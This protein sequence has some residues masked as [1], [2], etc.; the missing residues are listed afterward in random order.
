MNELPT[1]FVVR[2]L[3]A[4]DLPAAQALLDACET[5]DTGEPTM[6]E[7]YLAVESRSPR[8][9]FEHGAW[10]IDANDGALAGVGWMRVPGDRGISMADHYV[11]PDL[12]H[13]AL[14]DVFLDLIEAR[15]AEY[16]RDSGHDGL[17]ELP[18]RL[19]TYSEPVLERRRELLLARGFAVV[20]GTFQMRLDL[21]GPIAPARFPAGIIVRPARLGEDDRLLHA[22]DEEAF[23]EHFG[24]QDWT[25]EEWYVHTLQDERVDPGL[26]LVAWDGAEVAGQAWALPHEG[27]V[28]VDTLAVRRPWRGR[29]LGLA[30]L[31]E[32]FRL[33]AGRGY[34]FVRLHVDAQNETGALELYLKAGMRVERCF[35]AFEK[36]FG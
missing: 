36:V 21:A 26:W 18:V 19:L 13:L 17:G 9:D 30:L 23:R 20:R 14:D 25:F 6:H 15:A 24:H 7:T 27:E 35:E 5:A 1:G 34:P 32:L 33:L 29:G 4:E 10:T 8:F 11:R 22:A 12:R 28:W 3:T 2:H 16:A 31:Q